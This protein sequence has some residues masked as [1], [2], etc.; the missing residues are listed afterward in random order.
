MK[1]TDQPTLWQ[2]FILTASI[3]TVIILALTITLPIPRDVEQLLVWADTAVCSIFLADFLVIF[4]R[5]KKKMEYLLKWGRIDLLS[6]V[7]LI[8]AFRWGRLARIIRILRLFKGVKSAAQLVR[9]FARNRQ[10]TACFTIVLLTGATLTFSSI[11][12]LIAEK[13]TGEINTPAKALWWCLTTITTVGYGDLYP[14]TSIGKIV[15]AITMVMGIAI[16]SSLTALITS[17]VIEPATD[18]KNQILEKLDQ[19]TTE[20]REI[21]KRLG[22]NPATFSE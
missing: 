14:E 20:M 8:E 5:S 17:V 19:L 7:P 18:V 4:F 15:A 3:T 16:F 22:D 6:A 2:L 12:I 1:E 9:A 11:A 10:Q 13:E 21:K